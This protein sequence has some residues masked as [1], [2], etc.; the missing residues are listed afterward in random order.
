MS[1]VKQDHATLFSTGESTIH[2]EEVGRHR[3]CNKVQYFPSKS[4][5]RHRPRKPA[6]SQSDSQIR[7]L[8]GS[9]VCSPA[10]SR[11][12]SP[13]G[14]HAGSAVKSK[15]K[16][17]A[18]HGQAG[19]ILREAASQPREPSRTHCPLLK[20][21]VHQN[22]S[23]AA[24]KTYCRRPSSPACSPAVSRSSGPTDSSAR[25][26]SGSQTSHPDSGPKGLLAPSCSYFRSLS[27]S[28]PDLTDSGPY[29]FLIP[30]E[31][32][33]HSLSGSLYNIPDSGPRSLEIEVNSQ[34]TSE[35]SS[36]PQ[37]FG[38]NKMKKKVRSEKDR[39]MGSPVNSHASSR[40]CR[41]PDTNQ[42][43]SSVSSR[44]L[45]HKAVG[46]PIR[47]AACPTEGIGNKPTNNKV[48]PCAQGPAWTPKTGPMCM[49]AS[50]R[51]GPWIQR[52]S[53][54]GSSPAALATVSRKP[55]VGHFKVW[56]SNSESSSPSLYITTIEDEYGQRRH[57][58]KGLQNLPAER[59]VRYDEWDW[60]LVMIVADNEYAVQDWTHSVV[61]H[62]LKDL[63]NSYQENIIL[64]MKSVK[65]GL[66][67]KVILEVLR[68]DGSIGEKVREA[69]EIFVRM[70]EKFA[71]SP[72]ITHVQF[73]SQDTIR[74]RHGAM[75]GH[76]LRAQDDNVRMD[77]CSNPPAHEFTCYTFSGLD[78][79]DGLPGQ[80]I[81]LCVLQEPQT[82]YFLVPCGKSPRLRAIQGT[83]LDIKI[84][85]ITQADPR[86]FRMIQ[87]GGGQGTYFL[88]PLVFKDYYLEF[89]V[90][91]GLTLQRCEP[92]P[93]VRCE[94]ARNF[95]FEFIPVGRAM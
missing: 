87:A 66:Y 27:N 55:M 28:C 86:F 23:H 54:R 92:P 58:V 10:G 34:K 12:S 56:E 31:S 1:R 22:P 44:A 94:T 8:P 91:R 24:W 72:D 85:H 82:N 50:R 30:P 33:A 61:G 29:S 93:Y 68:E 21:A 15:S 6:Y 4:P 2:H 77:N 69:Y 11:S 9:P 43:H 19:N 83:E 36:P 49:P 52:S 25:S 67:I 20:Q 39:L 65:N 63:I 70:I 32:Y 17:A 48:A 64:I 13:V 16:H 80:T 84:E 51:T 47:L 41:L 60:E 46:A 14:I 57:H 62:W 35:Q 88:K 81:F 78:E 79:T 38:V 59:G 76:Y 7:S 5:E 42:P 53:R 89:N 71:V 37:K 18:R 26:F 90:H 3:N 75:Y 73:Q 95:T 45:Q 40:V 74:V